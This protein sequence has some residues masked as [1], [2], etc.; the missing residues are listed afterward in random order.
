MI[1]YRLTTMFVAVAVLAFH[2]SAGAQDAPQMPPR[3]DGAVKVD[4]HTSAPLQF[5]RSAEV[6]ESAGAVW[7]YLTNSNNVAGL[8]DGVHSISR[9][10]VGERRTV[11]L[12]SGGSVSETVL[13]DDAKSRTFAYSIADTNPMDISD[14]LAVLTVTSADERKGSVVTWN[15]YFNAAGTDASVSMSKSLTD[16]LVKLSAKHGGYA[17]HGSNSG[18][19]PAIV[20]Q[21]R[22]LKASKAD[23]WAV[24]ADGFGDAHVWSS[25]I[26]KIT[27]T[28][29]NGDKIVGDQRACFIPSFNGETKETITQYD[30]DKGV[31]AYSIDQGMPPFVTYGEA[32]WLVNEI[33]S[34]TTQITVEITAATAPGVP[35]QA[36]AFFRGAMTQQ[37]VV[38]VD[39]AK[40]FIENDAVHPR[41]T[42]ALQAA[43]GGN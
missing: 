28:D 12:R 9:A 35:P 14:H 36:I 11:R 13:A 18:F 21:T 31:F 37:V 2:L 27:V 19:N 38:A 39:D 8:F 16:A 10:K 5:S 25:N 3:T 4:E 23:V 20:R 26:G 41:K 1:K 6:S 40:Y 17:D 29:R 15:H 7:K 43:G 32:V 24:V 33:D 22:I 34:D 42:A 30:E